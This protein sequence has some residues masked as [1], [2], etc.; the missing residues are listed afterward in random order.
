[1]FTPFAVSYT[2]RGR[3]AAW[4][5]ATAVCMTFPARGGTVSADAWRAGGRRRERDF[6]RPRTT[7]HRTLSASACSYPRPARRSS[8]HE[9]PFIELLTDPGVGARLPCH[10]PGMAI[11]LGRVRA[12]PR[13]PR[14]CALWVEY[15]PARERPHRLLW[16]ILPQHG[17]EERAICTKSLKTLNAC[18]LAGMGTRNPTVKEVSSGLWWRTSCF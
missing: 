8:D 15:R 18:L 17:V 2:R 5:T 14:R 12:V 7:T 3:P 9:A 4:R 1:M 10:D 16:G 11:R 13:V 6:T